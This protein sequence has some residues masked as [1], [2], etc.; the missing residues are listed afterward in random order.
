MPR[1]RRWAAPE[2]GIDE[3]GDPDK[4]KPDRNACG[5]DIEQA[6]GRNA[7]R[8]GK[9]HHCQDR[10]EHAAVKRHA[11]LPNGQNVERIGEIALQVV[12]QDVADAPA[13][14]DA[15]RRPRRENRPDPQVS[16][17]AYCWPT[18]AASTPAFFEYHQANRMPT[19]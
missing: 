8:A 14:D 12:E 10:A 13:E 1:E 2:F 6:P 11:A 7:A 18:G 4:A 16:S 15:E 17:G 3:V 5:H 19:T 9:Q